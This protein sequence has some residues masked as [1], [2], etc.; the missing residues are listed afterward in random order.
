MIN[1]NDGEEKEKARPCPHPH[2]ADERRGMFFLK[3]KNYRVRRTAA[4][5]WPE[6]DPRFVAAPWGPRVF[7]PARRSDQIGHVPLNPSP[8]FP[9]HVTPA[10]ARD[11]ANCKHERPT[12]L[13]W[14]FVKLA[15]VVYSTNLV[16]LIV[17]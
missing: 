12:S 3:K 8:H 2:R 6:P 17:V 1:Y 16:P 14:H 5:G 9:F 11:E 4:S 10:S 15:V 7:N 13:R